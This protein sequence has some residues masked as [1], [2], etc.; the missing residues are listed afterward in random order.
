MLPEA[1]ETLPRWVIDGALLGVV[2]SLVVAGLFYVMVRYFPGERPREKRTTDSET[3]RRAEMRDYL[4][5]IGEQ[6]A[7]GH[8]VEGQHVAFY[9]PKRDV[10]IT[11]DARAYYR[12]AHSET[13]PV[14]VEHEL[15]GVALGYR[16]P[17]ET[18]DVDFDGEDALDPSE[19]AYAALGLPTGASVEDVKGAYRE[20]V[21]EVHPDHGGDEDEFKRLREAYTTAKKHAS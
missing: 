5:A 4:D 8:F 9:L 13:E 10:A 16:L 2:L 3:R 1:L 14:L 12:I 21:K 20:R 11:F 17:F 19:A 7:E 6:Y 15:P 18:P